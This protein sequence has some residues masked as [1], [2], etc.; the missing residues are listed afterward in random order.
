MEKKYTMVTLMIMLFLVLNI[1]CKGELQSRTDSKTLVLKGMIANDRKDSFRETLKTLTDIADKRV[2]A[3]AQRKILQEALDSESNTI[4]SHSISSKMSALDEKISNFDEQVD[5]NEKLLVVKGEIFE[6]LRDSLT[7]EEK[8]SLREIEVK[9]HQTSYYNDHVEGDLRRRLTIVYEG[10]VETI[11]NQV[12]MI[13]NLKAKIDVK[14]NELEAMEEI[15][16]E[17]TEG[18]KNE[19]LELENKLIEA[20]RQQSLLTLI[21]DNLVEEI[22]SL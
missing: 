3:L 21:K 1:G 4:I 20:V 2:E 11:A 7:E 17:K 19:I 10:Q 22:R 16:S 13:N 15:D 18:L 9:Q 14:S 12:D 5:L 6:E 8:I